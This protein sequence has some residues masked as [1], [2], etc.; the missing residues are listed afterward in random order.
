M[1]SPVISHI[2]PHINPHIIIATLQTSGYC[3]A[4]AHVRDDGRDL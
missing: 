4:K 1:I 2:N 3:K